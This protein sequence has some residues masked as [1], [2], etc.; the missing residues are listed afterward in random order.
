MARSLPVAGLVFACA[1]CGV[2][3]KVE[4][5]GG[6]VPGVRT[7]GFYA[8]DGP[9]AVGRAHSVEGEPARAPRLLAAERGQFGASPIFR[10]LRECWLS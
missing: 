5:E 9:C 6:F 2:R 4:G 3:R 7:W 1:T 8:P 10:L